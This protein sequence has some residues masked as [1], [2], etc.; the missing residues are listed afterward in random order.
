METMELGRVVVEARIEN[1]DDEWKV[2]EG[3]LPAGQI[4]SIIVPDALVDSG[5][6]QLSLPISLIRQ[7]GL[8]KIKEKNIRSATGTARVGI[9]DQVH[10]YIQGRDAKVEVTEL[11][12]GT[13]VL[14]GQIPLEIMDWVIDM[15]GQKLIGNPAHGGNW[16]YELYTHSHAA[17][18]MGLAIQ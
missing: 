14:I 6:S 15:K 9:Y 8:K 1:L 4:R 16:E 17:Y 7:L 3:L 2:R 12:D 13:P 11:P 10:L 18:L 5:A